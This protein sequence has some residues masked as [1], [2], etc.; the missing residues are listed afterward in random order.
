MGKYKYETKKLKPLKKGLFIPL[1]ALN[2]IITG[3]IIIVVLLAGMRSLSFESNMFTVGPIVLIGLVLFLF[4]AFIE[5]RCRNRWEMKWWHYPL[6]AHWIPVVFWGIAFV[7]ALTNWWS[8]RNNEDA[9]FFRW[10]TLTFLVYMA[11]VTVYRIIVHFISVGLDKAADT[12]KDKKKGK[13]KK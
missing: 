8:D 10:F 3:I 5:S 6:A 13:G 2:S 7:I 1:M 4:H 11:V 12:S 9:I